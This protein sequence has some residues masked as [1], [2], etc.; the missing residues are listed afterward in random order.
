MLSDA[1][2]SDGCEPCSAGIV[3]E[4]GGLP[5]AQDAGVVGGGASVCET[6]E[7]R[8]RLLLHPAVTG[9]PGGEKA[10]HAEGPGRFCARTTP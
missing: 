2:L 6:S 10:G 8:S 5:H 4:D 7:E 3:R 9:Q 1:L